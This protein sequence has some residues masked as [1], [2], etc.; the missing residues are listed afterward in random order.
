M[1]SIGLFGLLNADQNVYE[2]ILNLT[3]FHLLVVSACFLLNQEK[4]STRF[5]LAFAIV[6]V[7]GYFIELI[8]TTTGFPFGN[9][10]YGTTMGWTIKGVPVLI[11]LNW[12][13]LIFSIAS[14]IHQAWNSIWI[15][16]IVGALLMVLFDLLLEPVAQQLGYWQWHGS[17]I[18]NQNYLA[19]FTI[20]FFLFLFLFKAN[21]HVNNRIGIWVYLIQFLF[22]SI[23]LLN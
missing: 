4:F 2:T 16:S 11:G 12:A 14:V 15:K 6:F 1:H 20:S 22:L 21:I 19:W 17:I 9:Y 13:L 5:L 18:P 7:F 8:G 10:T 3:P 23:L